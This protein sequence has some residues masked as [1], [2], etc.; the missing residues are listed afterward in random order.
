[1][2][3]ILA[4]LITSTA[5]YANF[6]FN[7][8]TISFIITVLLAVFLQFPGLYDQAR[9]IWKN[10]SA[11]GVNTNTFIIFLTFF[12]VFIIYNYSISSGAGMLNGVILIIP[13]AF[14]LIGLLK[15]ADFRLSYLLTILAG[16]IV[17]LLAAILSN[18]RKELFILVSSA[19]FVALWLQPLEMWKSKM[20]KNVSKSFARN[21]LI[22]SLAWVLY[23]IVIGDWYIAS[24]SFAFATAYGAMLIL[25]YKLQTV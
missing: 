13:Q 7:S 14:I 1:M 10:Q 2:Y 24:T 20:V 18:F 12:L 22:V 25:W 17:V 19:V 5:E 8:I 16:F 3:N 9:T 21:F 15:F 6:G 4:G 23:G 11:V